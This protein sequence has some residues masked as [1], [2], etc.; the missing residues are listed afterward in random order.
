MLNIALSLLFAGGDN[1]KTMLFADAVTG[2]ADIVIAPF[3]RMVVL[4]IREANSI[5]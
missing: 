2:A 5:P 3:V 1:G 4:V